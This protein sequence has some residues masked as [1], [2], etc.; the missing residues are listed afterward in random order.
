M[1]YVLIRHDFVLARK[2]LLL[3]EIF[4]TTFIAYLA[5]FVTGR[6][7][8]ILGE[9][10]FDLLNI[11]KFFYI[12]KFPGMLFMGG[13]LGF[14]LVAYLVFL[15]KKILLRIFDI[16]C[17]SMYPIFIFALVSSYSAGY[18]LYFNVLIFLLSCVFLGL[19]IY[20]YK[21]YALKDGSITFLFLS[22]VSIFT[23]VSEFSMKNR[24]VFS[25]F[26]IPQTVA[27]GA[28]LLFSVLLLMHEGMIKNEKRGSG[29]LFFRK[30]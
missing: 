21:S 2:S 6:M 18:F 16:Y 14:G 13:L 11:L 4:D 27:I 15:K 17:L 10:R 20:S 8:Y 24:V 26:T 22:L 28:F 23:I 3:Q 1:L 25:F 29:F 12:S 7:S 9:G 30:R 19:G 5:F